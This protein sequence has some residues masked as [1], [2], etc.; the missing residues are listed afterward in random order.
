[1][2]RLGRTLGWTLQ[3]KTLLQTQR[4]YPNTINN[5]CLGSKSLL[6]HRAHLIPPSELLSLRFNSNTFRNKLGTKV[7]DRTRSVF[8]I[9]RRRFRDG[10]LKNQN[11]YGTTFN[12]IVGN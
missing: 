8:G 11:T 9:F 5:N 10:I 2:Q 1:M 4:F 7:W 6:L 12:E 3:T